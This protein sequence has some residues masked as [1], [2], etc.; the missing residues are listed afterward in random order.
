M[1]QSNSAMNSNSGKRRERK[2]N[3]IKEEAQGKHQNLRWRKLLYLQKKLPT[4]QEG[5]ELLLQQLAF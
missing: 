2:K 3:V 4:K 5:G 1:T